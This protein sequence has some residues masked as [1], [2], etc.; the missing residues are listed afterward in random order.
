MNTAFAIGTL[1]LTLAV[2]GACSSCSHS[3]TTAVPVE[4]ATAATPEA[5]AEDSTPRV[6]ECHAGSLPRFTEKS[7][8]EADLGSLLAAAAARPIAVIQ[9]DAEVRLVKDCQLPGGPYFE[10][11]GKKG[12][13]M[14]RPA[15][16]VIFRTDELTGA[17]R[18]A[19]HVVAAFAVDGLSTD[20]FGRQVGAAGAR[21]PKHLEGIL[22]P[23]PCPSVA[24]PKAAP[25]CVGRGLTG[26]QRRVQAKELWARI[27]RR[28]DG[29]ADA[30]EPLNVYALVPDHFW[31]ISLS[32]WIKDRVLAE[33]GSWLFNEYDQGKFVPHEGQPAWGGD[34]TAVNVSYEPPTT[35]L[36][37]ASRRQAP[38][39][40][41]WNLGHRI[42]V[43][44]L[45]MDCFLGLA[46]PDV[47]SE[48]I[49]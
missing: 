29:S 30:A 25:G 21:E 23:L 44:P 31:G 37:E 36:K 32:H 19:T 49:F 39:T 35:T 40:F 10:M 5:A 26:N 4:G 27:P 17:C 45:F 41:H 2:G 34:P 20:E 28:E 47:H 14:F 22:I 16:R 46:D 33:Q 7:L 42:F 18:A 48:V 38:P 8:V 13:G 15:S 43:K 3:S 12:K 11:P 6:G 24:D 1:G 9:T